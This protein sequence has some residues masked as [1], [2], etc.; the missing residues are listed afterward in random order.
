MSFTTVYYNKL[1]ADEFGSFDDHHFEDNGLHDEYILDDF[2]L[3]DPYHSYNP[4]RPPR[5]TRPNRQ[6]FSKPSHPSTANFPD[7]HHQGRPS[8]HGTVN[9]P[10]TFSSLV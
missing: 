10:S 4:T 1:D 2:A 9:S 8:S 6:V 7:P 3:S 5:P